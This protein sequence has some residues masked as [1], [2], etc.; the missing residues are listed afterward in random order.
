[1]NAMN[2]AAMDNDADDAVEE[3]AQPKTATSLA[4]LGAA[5]QAEHIKWHGTGSI[6]KP[7]GDIGDMSLSHDK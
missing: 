3:G 2:S 6:D 7:P 5:V 1:M 4:E